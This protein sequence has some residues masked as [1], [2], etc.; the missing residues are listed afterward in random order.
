MLRDGQT[1]V[2]DKAIYDLDQAIMVVTG[3]GLKL[4]T[5]TMW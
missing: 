3:K 1:V 4:T 5:A 2:G